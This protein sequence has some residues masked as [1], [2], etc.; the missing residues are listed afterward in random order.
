M[1]SLHDIATL[2]SERIGAVI[3]RARPVA[4]GVALLASACGGLAYLVGALV[5][6]G[7]WRYGW[8]IVGLVV[9]AAP[10]WSLWTAF[11]RLQR[12]TAALPSTTAQ[13]Q[14]LTGDRQVR[15]ALYELVDKRDDVRA[16]PIIT[17]GKDLNRLR[18]AV[19]S[20]RQQLS[21]LW[22][23]I[24]AVTSLPGLLAVGIVGSFGLLI[25]SVVVVLV[26]LAVR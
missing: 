9:C 5:L 6:R 16:T 7:G 22:E 3:S 21:G 2:A 13:L 12:A 24:T 23:T 14:A 15:D 10:A 8:L 4:R 17:L 26:G 25:F 18:K 1:A 19:S 20:H 11:R